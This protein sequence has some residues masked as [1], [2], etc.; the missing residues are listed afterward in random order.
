MARTVLPKL[1]TVLFSELAN[2]NDR[3]VI[4]VAGTSLELGLEWAITSRLRK[5]I[6]DKED[7]KLFG[8]NSGLFD[9]FSSKLWAAYFLKIIGPTVRGDMDIV[10]RMRNFAAHNL[11]PISFAMP[12]I[13]GRCRELKMTEQAVK[14]VSIPGMDPSTTKA[15][16]SATIAFLA[17]NLLRRAS[18]SDYE[19]AEKTDIITTA[20]DN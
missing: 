12:E 1:T 20:L 14:M 19:I 17:T 6:N 7:A 5:P 2:E 18:L 3:A 11:D 9:S 8:E 4:L 13:A 10:R 15:Q 16:F